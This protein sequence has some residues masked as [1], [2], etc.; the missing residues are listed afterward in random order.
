M[1]TVGQI[2]KILG[3]I[4]KTVK[5]TPELKNISFLSEHSAAL[6]EK[7]ID[8]DCKINFSDYLLEQTSAL[9]KCIATKLEQN[10]Q[11]NAK[12]QTIFI[13]QYK[14]CKNEYEKLLR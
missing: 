12:I 13:R 3:E 8:K 7:I 4:E 10:L 14:K 2:I 11:D 5:S 6:S 9:K 1:N